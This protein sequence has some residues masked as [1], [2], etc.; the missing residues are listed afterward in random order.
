MHTTQLRQE[1]LDS[2]QEVYP[3]WLDRF[4]KIYGELSTDNLELLA[5]IYHDDIVFKDPMHKLHGFKELSEYFEN[6]Y[7][8]LISCDFTINEIVLDGN[9]AGIYWHMCYQH[10]KLNSG[11]KIDVMGHSKLIGQDDKVIYHQDYIDLGAM[12]Y[13]HLPVLGR[14]IK[15]LKRRAVQ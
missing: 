1:P 15:W 4:V 8:N 13:E 14:I 11:N 6:L 5:D 3:V 10:P 7:T 12:L 2:S 9:T